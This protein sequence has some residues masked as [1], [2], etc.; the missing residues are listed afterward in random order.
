MVRK[1]LHG[2]DERVGNTRPDEAA[3]KSATAPNDRVCNVLT[4]SDFN[5]ATEGRSVVLTK[6]RRPDYDA[7]RGRSGRTPLG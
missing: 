1:Q 2:V 4:G 5:D 7:A 3:W 6:L